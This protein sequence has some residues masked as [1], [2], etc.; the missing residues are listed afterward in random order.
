MIVTK[1]EEAEQSKFK[2]YIDEEYAFLLNQKDLE[3]YEISEGCTISQAD[4]EKIIENTVFNR[5][6]QKALSVLKFMDR[7][8]QELR[9]KLKDA[10]YTEDIINRTIA[11]VY[12][13]GYL[14]DERYA[15]IYIRDR[16]NTKSKLIIRNELLH[17]G[18]DKSIIDRIIGE[19][20]E[21]D[22]MDDDA[23]L[24]AIRKAV[25]KKTKSPENL[26]REDKQKL[27]A[28]LYRKGFEISKIRQILD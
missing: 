24:M 25:A 14:N 6:K 9:R 17:K 10:G 20:Y 2:I 19:E 13:Y 12:E 1:L 16:M 15:S 21:N 23:E 26:S 22:D 4:Y 7:T 28:S 5:A 18:I 11:Y 8:E 3:Q 27:I